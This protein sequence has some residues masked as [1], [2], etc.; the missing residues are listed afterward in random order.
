MLHYRGYVGT[1][2]TREIW[3]DLLTI[4]NRSQIVRD[5][6]VVKPERSPE[7]DLGFEIGSLIRMFQQNPASSDFTWGA[8][9]GLIGESPENYE[10]EAENLVKLFD[11][12][13]ERY[14]WRLFSA[15]AVAD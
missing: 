12:L 1:E 11:D 5:A 6:P 4:T 15:G 14:E 13:E 7:I 9:I 10:T 3:D 8:I 2:D